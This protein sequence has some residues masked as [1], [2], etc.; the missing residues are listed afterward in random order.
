MLLDQ[1]LALANRGGAHGSDSL[2]HGVPWAVKVTSRL[3]RAIYQK[4]GADARL[5]ARGALR[6]YAG[7]LSPDAAA[8]LGVAFQR[9]AAARLSQV[10]GVTLDRARQRR[11]PSRG[12]MRALV[13]GTGGRLRWQH[14]PAPPPPPAQGA[15]VRPIA[16]S[17]CDIDCAI[18]LGASQFPLPL[19]LGHECVAEILAVGEH[20][21]SFRPGDRVVVPFQIN[22]GEC[23]ACRAGRTGNCTG[24]PPVSMYGMGM[25]GGV[26]GGAFAEQLAVPYAEAM[27]VRLPGG[28]DPVAAASAADNICDAYRHIAPH[29]P[30][31]LSEDPDA[32]V[33]ILAATKT[34]F[35]FS[36]SLPLYTG[37]IARAFGA[38]RVL[39]ADARRAVREHA[40][41]L[42]LD[43]L[44]PRE[45]R[46]MP[47]WPLVIDVSAGA[48]RLA[49]TSTAPDGTCTSSG[50]LHRSAR[51]PTLQMYGRNVTLHF[52]RTHARA[53]MPEVLELLASGR[54]DPG[55]IVT[56]VAPLEDAPRALGEHFR[57]GGVKT[58]ITAVQ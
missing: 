33:L 39:L 4:K 9:D 6:H 46:R 23:R 45:L 58:V 52:G 47:P 24:V 5:R 51:I 32:E 31:L 12:R 49:L 28:V 54:L 30:Q 42:G 29:L 20:V 22:C 13:A 43:A 15:V 17:T 56:D 1:D 18:A 44:H 36:P 35:Y 48:L 26:W 50:S 57:G 19:H 21:S 34:P 2:R 38:T 3:I 53:L 11:R 40:Q 7:L 25:V 14:V 41:R 37:L 8:G 55:P 16:S 27:L 10:A